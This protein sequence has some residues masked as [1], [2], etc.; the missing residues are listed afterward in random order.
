ME[1]QRVIDFNILSDNCEIF[2]NKPERIDPWRLE[3]INKWKEIHQP[4]CNKLHVKVP[5]LNIYLSIKKVK[6]ARN[7]E[8]QTRISQKCRQC[9]VSE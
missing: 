6:H 1:C 4:T 2:L 9:I 5:D 8:I 3:M 7:Y